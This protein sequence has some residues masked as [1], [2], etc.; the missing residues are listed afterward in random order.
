VSFRA[1]ARVL[2]FD[3]SDRVLMFLQYGKDRAVVPRWITPGGGV[4]PGE[5]FD[6]AA[7]RETFEETGLRLDSVP[8]P[9]LVEDFDPD[10]RWHPYDTGRW[11][12]YALR[13]DAFEPSRAGW[14]EEE[15]V[16]VV[17]WRWMSAEELGSDEFECEPRHLPDLVRAHTPPRHG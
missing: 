12:W 14:T 9:F 7:I 15:Q 11:A 4:D 1:T 10:Q 17:Q 8:A 13:V 2:L 5:D 3:E 6:A 16:D